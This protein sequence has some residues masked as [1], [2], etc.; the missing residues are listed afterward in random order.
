MNACMSTTI[1]TTYC[2]DRRSHI[3]LKTCFSAIFIEYWKRKYAQQNQNL[4]KP[5]FC[6]FWF[7]PPKFWD[8]IQAYLEF[9]FTHRLNLKESSQ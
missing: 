3:E 7:D 8:V 4:I 2:L 5:T 1:L 9:I 6:W